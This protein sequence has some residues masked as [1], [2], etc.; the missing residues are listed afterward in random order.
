[1]V[2]VNDLVDE[3]TSNDFEA[4]DIIGKVQVSHVY[5]SGVFGSDIPV[6]SG[7]VGSSAIE[8]SDNGQ[9]MG[10]SLLA[11]ALLLEGRRVI[12]MRD[13]PSLVVRTTDELFTTEMKDMLLT[14]DEADEDTM[15]EGVMWVNDPPTEGWEL[16]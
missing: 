5:C 13:D 1:M 9:A 10:I 16:Q 3:M 15:E 11:Q 7:T 12:K 8:V 14:A 4:A 6:T 2:D